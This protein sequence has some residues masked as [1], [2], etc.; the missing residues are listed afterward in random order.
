MRL[1][2]SSQYRKYFEILMFIGA[3]GY[4]AY[5]WISG[6]II[7][8][9]P[10]ITG[11][12][13]F[14]DFTNPLK[15]KE[16]YITFLSVV[17]FLISIFTVWEI[18]L[19]VVEGFKKEKV[20]KGISK[21]TSIFK[22][23]ARCFKATFLAALISEFLPELIMIDIFRKIQPLFQHLSFFKINF[24]WYSWVYVYL[25]WELS[26]WVRHY[27][28]HRIK[29]LWCLHSPHHAPEDLTMTTAW[30]N[31]F[32]EGYYTAFVQ[33]FI[34]SALGVQPAMLLAI[35]SIEVTWGTFIHAGER[36]LKTG[37][38]GTLKHFLITTSHH[39]VHHAK[40]PLYMDTNF[41]TFLPFW[42]WLFGTLQPLR[43][44]V[45]IEYGMTRKTDIANF[46]DF[47]F[48]EFRLSFKDVRKAK[49]IINKLLYL[50]K[51]PGWHPD[52]I[53][54]TAATVRNNFL[55]ANPEPGLTSRN[56]IRG[57]MQR[58]E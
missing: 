10:T 52:S 34:L 43:N 32:A 33:W 13:F 27:S 3:F 9:W 26:T 19:L 39:R 57:K 4:I 44:E 53:E 22:Y 51:P 16:Y 29:L 46:I 42:D 36:S 6:L 37:R 15:T 31:F 30:V 55:K 28:T 41:C 38:L 50:I 58:L 7:Y 17:A 18:C 40:N 21:A 35:M 11:K 12:G 47:Y 24:A 23:A 49:G 56:M 1:K 8:S 25:I 45:K 54:N 5:A 48:G 14:D 2:K 20:K